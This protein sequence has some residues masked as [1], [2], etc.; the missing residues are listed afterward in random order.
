MIDALEA[1]MMRGAIAALRR[2]AERQR[3]VASDWTVNGENG[4]R[5]LS[6]EGRI[7]ERIAVALDQA[8]DEFERAARG[9]GFG[10]GKEFG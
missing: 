4:V 1:D 9:P 2:R 7:A 8:A 5:I 3:K 6:V 10:H